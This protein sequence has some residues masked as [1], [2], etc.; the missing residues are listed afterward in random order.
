[1]VKMAV[2]DDNK[3]DDSM[4]AIRSKLIPM[5]VDEPDLEFYAVKTKS[6]KE[7]TIVRNVIDGVSC[8]LFFVSILIYTDIMLN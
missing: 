6:G 4:E 3:H 7:K 8:F 1:M 2:P 5:I